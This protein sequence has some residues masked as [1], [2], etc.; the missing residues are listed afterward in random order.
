MR[1]HY[2]Q[3]LDESGPFNSK[4]EIVEK[5]RGQ[6][7]THAMADYANSSQC[8]FFAIAPRAKRRLSSVSDYVVN[9]VH[10]NVILLKN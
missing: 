1:T 7:L 10:C 8:D 9:H 4:F 2:Q 6:S 5:D 3:D